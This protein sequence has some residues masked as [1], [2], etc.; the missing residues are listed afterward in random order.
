MVPIVD[1]FLEDRTNIV[2]AIES[3]KPRREPRLNNVRQFFLLGESYTLV[4]PGE[5]FLLAAFAIS[6]RSLPGLFVS[7]KIELKFRAIRW[8]HAERRQRNWTGRLFERD[9]D[10]SR[11]AWTDAIF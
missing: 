4:V 3:Q 6:K 5:N 1:L 2:P 7:G 10:K 11:L 8:G 9:D